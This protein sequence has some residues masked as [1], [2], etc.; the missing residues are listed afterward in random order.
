MGVRTKGEIPKISSQLDAMPVQSHWCAID[1]PS[2]VRFH[3]SRRLTRDHMARVMFFRPCFLFPC[4]I[5]LKCFKCLKWNSMLFIFMRFFQVSSI[6]C[7]YFFDEFLSCP[8]Y[9]F[10][11][12]YIFFVLISMQHVVIITH[13]TFRPFLARHFD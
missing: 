1:D 10:Y 12:H 11:V 13:D 8:F 6:P 5:L 7:F 4:H 9:F 2:V 3:W